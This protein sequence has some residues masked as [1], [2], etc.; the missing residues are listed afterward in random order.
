MRALESPF[1]IAPAPVEIS[2]EWVGEYILH[3]FQR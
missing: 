1:P 3:K 2:G